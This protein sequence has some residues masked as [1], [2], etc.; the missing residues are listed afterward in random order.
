MT[1]KVRVSAIQASPI[2]F[3]LPACLEKYDRLIKEACDAYQPDL[4]VLPEASLSAY[5]RFLDFQ[6]GTRTDENR[7]WFSRYVKVS[8]YDVRGRK[9]KQIEIQFSI[10]TLFLSNFEI[11]IAVK[12]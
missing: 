2:A 11:L 1:S 4:V 10:L 6:I 9:L 7:Q 5:P 8:F 3:D 12:V